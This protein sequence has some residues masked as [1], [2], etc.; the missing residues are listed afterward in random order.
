MGN[1]HINQMLRLEYIVNGLKRKVIN[2]NARPRL[3]MTPEILTVMKEMWWIDSDRNKATI[4]WAATCT[5]FFGFLRSSKVVVPSYSEYDLV[6]HLSFGDVCLDNTTDPQ[7]L[8]VT[9]KALKTGPFHQGVQVY[10][11][12]TNTDFCPVAAVFSYMVYRGTDSDP[13]FRYT[14]IQALTRKRFVR[15]VQS[16]LQ[17]AGIDSERY[18]GHSFCIGATSTAAWWGLQDSLIKIFGRWESMAYSLYI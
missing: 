1:P 10:L 11:G 17:A 9:I 5:C 16:A 8:E 14:R 2:S 13:F 4:L 3:P 6:V 7:F 12:R 18:S 15:D